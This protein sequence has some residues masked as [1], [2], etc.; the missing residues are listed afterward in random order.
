MNKSLQ[1][2]K[3]FFRVVIEFL[4]VF[5]EPGKTGIL[6]VALLSKSAS[7]WKPHKLESKLLI[8]QDKVKVFLFIDLLKG[9]FNR[10]RLALF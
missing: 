3:T 1:S 6:W 7:Y 9:L 10:D 5:Q 4:V 2:K 8:N